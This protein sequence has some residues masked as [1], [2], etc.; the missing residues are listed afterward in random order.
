MVAP[1]AVGDNPVRHGNLLAAAA[2]SGDKNGPAGPDG[3]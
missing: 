1:A 3:P 2:G